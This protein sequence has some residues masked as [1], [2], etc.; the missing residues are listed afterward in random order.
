MRLLRAR[1]LAELA[2]VVSGSATQ[3][4][5]LRNRKVESQSGGDQSRLPGRGTVKEVR[6]GG[7]RER[8]ASDRSKKKVNRF[9]VRF[10]QKRKT[11]R[12]SCLSFGLD[13]DRGSAPGSGDVSLAII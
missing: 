11:G 12:L 7:R 3:S 13:N 2:K 6:R 1:G 4:L 9:R 5:W 8:R 10:G